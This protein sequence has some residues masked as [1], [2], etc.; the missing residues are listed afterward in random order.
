MWQATI[1]A[2]YELIKA[3][4]VN[5]LETAKHFI[6][7]IVKDRVSAIASSLGKNS[8]TIVPMSLRMRD[9]EIY[10]RRK[11]T[12]SFTFSY[13]QTLANI[14]STTG[15]WRPVPGSNWGRWAQSMQVGPANPRGFSG[16]ELSPGDDS[17]LD[18]CGGKIPP[19]FTNVTQLVANPPT[20]PTGIGGFDNTQGPI[21]RELR[22]F[23]PEPTPEASW[24]LYDCWVWIEVDSGTIP[25]RQLPKKPAKNI[26][27]RLLQNPFDALDVLPTAWDL[28][29]GAMPRVPPVVGNPFGGA[30]GKLDNPQQRVK[31]LMFVYLYGRAA[32]Y[33][34]PIPVPSLTKFGGAVPVMACRLDRGEGYGHG[35]TYSAGAAPIYGATWNLRYQI[36]DPPKGFYPPDIPNPILNPGG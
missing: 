30:G 33:G 32:R 12:F 34:F 16:L 10:G 23:F 36:P 3:A 8:N 6:G 7:T 35:I 17:I 29:N 11:S 14:L 26:M 28:F 31:P 18:G 4:P 24:L 15:L 9:P 5:Q 25:V 27:Q 19:V 22:N 20:G 13:T 1:N 2:E 21:P